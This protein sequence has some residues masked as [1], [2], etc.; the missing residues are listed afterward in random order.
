MPYTV[1]GKNIKLLERLIKSGTEFGYINSRNSRIKS[2]VVKSQK[3]DEYKIEFLIIAGDGG[4]AYL[5][6]I[7]NKDLI[8]EFNKVKR[9]N[10]I[11][12]E[13]TPEIISKLKFVK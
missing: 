12:D 5:N 8:K 6:A 10:H 11:I 13:Y 4:Q 2:M 1:K 9:Y 7:K 3:E